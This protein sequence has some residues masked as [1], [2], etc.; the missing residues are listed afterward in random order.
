MLPNLIDEDRGM[1]NKGVLVNPKTA[2]QVSTHGSDLYQNFLN[3]VVG[4]VAP[5]KE[6]QRMLN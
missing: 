1:K 3:L 4:V 2:E 5:G 6:I